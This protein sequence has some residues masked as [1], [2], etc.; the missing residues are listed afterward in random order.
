MCL[1]VFCIISQKWET[2]GRTGAIFQVFFLLIPLLHNN[3]IKI[4]IFIYIIMKIGKNNSQSIKAGNF[5]LALNS[6]SSLCSRQTW[7]MNYTIACTV[8]FSQSNSINKQVNPVKG[9]LLNP[10]HF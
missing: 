2:Q 10:G 7:I 9:L 8:I 5:F 1:F 6:P 3:I 4:R